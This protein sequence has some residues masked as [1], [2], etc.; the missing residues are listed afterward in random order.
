M[1]NPWQS[2][3][4]QNQY[5]YLVIT[6]PNAIPIS[7]LAA[8]R[9]ERLIMSTIRGMFTNPHDACL[10]AT[11]LLDMSIVI[12]T[13]GWKFVNKPGV[14]LVY[15]FDQYLRRH[16]NEWP[17]RNSIG[18]TSILCLPRNLFSPTTATGAFLHDYLPGFEHCVFIERSIL[19]FYPT[20]TPQNHH[21]TP[22]HPVTE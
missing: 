11:Y 12:S 10:L 20:T 8:D 7:N 15:D 6:L 1:T 13:T 16:N 22:F 17:P 5:I 3:P 9:A 14:T 18:R 19:Q 2:L 4:P 21:T